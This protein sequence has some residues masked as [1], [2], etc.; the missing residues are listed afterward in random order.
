MNQVFKAGQNMGLA[1]QV[2][3]DEANS[4]GRW[5]GPKCQANFASMDKSH[6][7]KADHSGKRSFW[8]SGREIPVS[9]PSRSMFAGRH[10][11]F[12]SSD[13]HLGTIE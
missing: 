2:G 6:A 3:S 5:G 11:A 1:R 4:T 13:R 7:A 12:P 8:N 9:V 10:E